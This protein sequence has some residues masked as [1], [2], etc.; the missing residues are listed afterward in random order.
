MSGGYRNLAIFKQGRTT[1]CDCGNRIAPGMM[2]C[3]DCISAAF[4]K[5]RALRIKDKIV[6]GNVY[7]ISVLGDSGAA[8]KFGYARTVADRLKH[9]QTGSPVILELLASCWAQPHHETMI[10]KRLVLSRSH[11]EWFTR[12]AEV[13]R[14]VE[15]IKANE[16]IEF[17]ASKN[18]ASKTCKV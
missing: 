15:M 17:L 14:V 6:S 18:G 9:L 10:H 3:H 7:A 11:G 1:W 4:E 2:M 16:I 5:I 8:I 12:T 13:M